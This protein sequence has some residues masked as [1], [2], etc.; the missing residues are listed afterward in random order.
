MRS[1]IKLFSA[2]VILLMCPLPQ[3]AHAS[4]AEAAQQG[5]ITARGTILDA[6]GQP[7][8]GASVFEKGNTSNGVVADANG[9]FTISV[10]A[11]AT[12]VFS[13]IGYQTLE[14]AATSLMNVTMLEDAEMLED[15]VVVGYGVQKK[16]TLTG[17]VTAIGSEEITTTKTENLISNIQ[18]KM[19]GLLIR[20]MTGEPGVFDNM[21]SIRG[22]GPPLIVID[23]VTRGDSSDLAQLNSDDIES[24]SILKD[25][26]AAIYGMNAANGVVIVTTKQ[27]K[28]Q[29][30]F[31]SYNGLFGM[32]QATGLEETLPVVEYMEIANERAKNDGNAGI[33][34]ED[35]INKYRNNEPGYS[36]FDWMSAYLK[37]FAFQQNHNISVR[38]GSDSVRYFV[39]LGYN[40][41][42]GLEKFDAQYYKRYTF[43]TNLTI[44]LTRDLTLITGLSGRW[45]ARQQPQEEFEW[46]YKTL[47]TNFRGTHPFTMD[48]EHPGQYTDHMS[49]VDPEGKNPEGLQNPDI[50][51]YRRNRYMS[52]NANAELR[53]NLPFLKGLTLSLFTSFDGGNG[54]N[55][56]LTK[57]Y[58]LYDFETDNFLST[59]NS[60]QSISSTMSIYQKLYG[61]AQITYANKF[62]DHNISATALVEGTGTR[63][64]NLSGSR[65]YADIFTNDILSQATPGTATNS[66][67]RSFTRQAAYIG[68]VNYDY[69]GKYLIELVGRYDGSY[70]YSPKLRWTFF[71]SASIGWRVSEEP[72]FKNLLPFV[73]NLKL[74]ASY[75]ESGL[76]T[77]NPFQY[78]SAYQSGDNYANSYI[79]SGSSIT[80]AY[81]APGVTLDNLSWVASKIMNVGLDFEAWRGKL[82]GTI[83]AFRRVNTGELASRIMSVPSTFGAS[84]PQENLQSSQNQGIEFEVGSRGN[85]GKVTYNI[86]GNFTY[87]RSK[88]LYRERREDYSSYDRW[89]NNNAY[90]LTGYRWFYQTD[91]SRYTNLEQLETAPLM[92]GNLGN[93]KILP[94]SFI[95][96]DVNGDGI[97]NGDDRLPNGW[98]RGTNP[99]IQ[100]GLNLYFAYAGFDINMLLQGAAGFTIQYPNDDIWGYGSKTNETYLLTKY[101]DRWHT[102][103]PSADPYDPSST[104]V[105]GLY[106]ALHKNF[107]GTLDNGQSYQIPFWHPN[108]AYVR[109]K[110]LEFGYTLPKSLLKKI[111]I[112]SVRVFVN[113]TNLFTICDPKLKK[114]DPER[115]ERDWQ[116]NAGYPLMKNYNFGLSVNF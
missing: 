1:L 48:P 3:L 60:T 16:E 79:L 28:A 34:S 103:D 39:S 21:I 27:G 20:Q 11:G 96:E 56:S 24:I 46:N 61:R 99:P 32:K 106:P 87:A 77:G 57:S 49:K 25:A 59:F 15:V 100:Y 97:I 29:K 102:A 73:N 4:E 91:E 63:R 115:E 84:F 88:Y 112:S 114:A 31:V 95:Y 8:I 44:N 66:G 23:G 7:V 22:Y 74:R 109:L 10:P 82:Y 45:T 108:G 70:R 51:G 113:G 105:T 98:A 65:N 43:R 107:T 67:D 36:D 75:G 89:K 18:G 86:S 83:E 68:R 26:S 93:S 104:W 6:Y 52:Y 80:T 41:D 37:P 13:S 17:A 72:F 47:I 58:P 76:D 71:P 33:Y 35:F 92:G 55:S 90:R 69:K 62:G 12:L 78:I 64:D 54:N 42:N 14:A 110:T 9:N 19:A 85:I 50:A 30:A 38:G 81:Y 94:G 2:A 40:D 5:R 101:A 53:Y 111:N 116:A